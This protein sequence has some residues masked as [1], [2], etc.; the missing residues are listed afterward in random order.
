MAVLSYIDPLV[1]VMISV[2]ILG[3][4]ITMLQVIG[5]CLILGFAVLNEI[6]ILKKEVRND[7]E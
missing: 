4:K 2:F 7:H 1:A 6:K 3:E 5:G